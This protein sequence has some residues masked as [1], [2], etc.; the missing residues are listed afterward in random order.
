MRRTE[1]LRRT[2]LYDQATVPAPDGTPLVLHRWAGGAAGAAVCYVHGIQSHAGWLHRTGPELAARGVQVY[3]LDRRGSGRSG[4]PR[5]HLPSADILLDDYA[6][7]LARVREWIGGLSLTA[8]G[9]S[10][11]GSVLAALLVRD[12]PAFDAVVFCAPALGQQR[13]RHTPEVLA[14]LRRLQGESRQPIPLVDTD[15]TDQPDE[16]AFMAADRLMVRE[17]TDQSKGTMVALEDRYIDAPA[18]A[19]DTPVYVAMPE[20]DPIIDLPA[21]R[22]VLH[23]LAPGVRE[24]VF[25]TDRHYLEFTPV[26]VDYWDWLA[27]V[28]DGTP[29]GSATT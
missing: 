28:A 9:Q 3:A 11:G 16:L 6:L 14:R 4:G 17:V 2:V 12:H 22:A 7:A 13:R 27:R 26:R 5:G 24:Q 20:H 19:G 23:R 21:A 29:S 10:L 15:Y 18:F 1:V 25:A 8:V